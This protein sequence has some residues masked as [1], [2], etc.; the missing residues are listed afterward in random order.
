MRRPGSLLTLQTALGFTLTIF[1]VQAVPLAAAALGW[2]L[3]LALL[4]IG[5]ALGILAMLPLRRRAVA[6]D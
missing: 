2:P 6:T 5:P 3:V 4:A 1:T